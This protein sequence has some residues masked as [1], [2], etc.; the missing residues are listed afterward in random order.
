MLG[1]PFVALAVIVATAAVAHAERAV[2]GTVVDDA[3]GMPVP[4]ALVAI[5]AHEAP[6]D[7]DGHFRVTDVPFGRVDVV[8]IADGYRAYFGSTRVGADLTVRLDAD[9]GAGEVISSLA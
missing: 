8:V 9:A 3:T 7:D 6:T 1:R 5:G 4:G 2:V